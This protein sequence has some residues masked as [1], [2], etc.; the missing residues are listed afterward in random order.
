MMKTMNEII[1]GDCLNVLP[2]LLPSIAKLI[3]TSPPYPGQRADTRTVPEWLAWFQD[4]VEA[5]TWPLADDGVLA[6]NVMFKRTE[7]GW[8]DSRL[9]TEIPRILADRGFSMIDVY[10]FTKPNP[11]PNGSFIY[12]DIPA[13][14]MV[15]VC[16]LA[17]SVHGYQ[18]NPVRRP[19]KAKSKRSNGTLY[20]SRSTTAALHPEGARPTN[21]LSFSSSGDQNRPK[22]Q[23]QS[24]PLALPER[25]IMQHTQPGDVV[26]DPFC[27]VG[28][29]C[30]AA[31]VNGRRYLG[32]ELLES[33][34]QLARE[35]LQRPFPL[36]LLEQS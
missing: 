33:E 20:T 8:F 6:L 30:R 34:A 19:Y 14:E 17:E 10:S 32:I 21:V 31:L 18:F 12:C 1:V 28:T 36:T 16:T 9:L 4:V 11:P 3:V 27:G 22:A 29:T 2:L 24:F 5:M 7:N 35:W 26:L 25:F 23:G 15:F 13:W